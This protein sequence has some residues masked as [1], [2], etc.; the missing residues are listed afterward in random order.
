MPD[1]PG[2]SSAAPTRYHSMWVTT[3][4]R[5][6]GITTTLR[7]FAS[8]NCVTVGAAAA[9][10]ERHAP[11]GAT[12]HEDERGRE[13]DVWARRALTARACAQV[14]RSLRGDGFELSLPSF[15]PTGRSR[16]VGIF[17]PPPRSAPTP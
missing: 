3:G 7:P 13:S 16:M 4:V 17:Q 1:L 11:S 6:S 5:R 12:R 10:A 14:A 2:G 8:V 15:M 9:C